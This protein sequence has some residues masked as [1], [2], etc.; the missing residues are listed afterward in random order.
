LAGLLLAVVASLCQLSATRAN[1]DLCAAEPPPVDAQ[2]AV[3]SPLVAQL[4]DPD[5]RV[6]TAASLALLQAGSAAAPL[7]T[8]AART[9]SLETRARAVEILSRLAATVEP[10]TADVVDDALESLQS[11]AGTVGERARLTWEQHRGLRE[12]RAVAMIE[13]LGGR[14]H[15]SERALVFVPEEVADRRIPDIEHIV[16]GKD[17]KGGD[18]GLKH[19]SRLSRL[20]VVYRVRQAPIS[21]AAV[22]KLA[23]AGVRVQLRGALLGVVGDADNNGELGCLIRAVREG[24][25]AHAAEL[26]PGDLIV[27]LD[28]QPVTSFEDLIKLLLDAEPEQEVRLTYRRG[29]DEY[30]ARLKL[31]AW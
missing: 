3:L 21:E 8:D 24:T 30:E 4:D 11:S 17:W 9:G 29:V 18:A 1:E 12:Q 27:K 25:P 23:D 28:D 16:I 31:G 14:V 10:Q 5:Y 20:G 15:F 26:L 22:E 2:R 19:L 13:K 6:R 7:L